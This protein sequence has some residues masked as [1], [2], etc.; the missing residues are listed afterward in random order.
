MV[1]GMVQVEWMQGVTAA[2]SSGSPLIDADTGRVVGVLTGGL[3]RKFC[4]LLTRVGGW[5]VTLAGDDV[6][7]R[8][9]ITSTHTGSRCG[10][11]TGGACFSYGPVG[12]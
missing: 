9:K 5:G 6:F 2:G 11:V 10:A 1:V 7:S 8:S 12:E 4:I 3:P